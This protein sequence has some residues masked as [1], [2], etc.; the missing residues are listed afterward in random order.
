VVLLQLRV[1]LGV[2]ENVAT[3]DAV[4]KLALAVA[5]AVLVR[6]PKNYVTINNMSNYIFFN[7]CSSAICYLIEL[8]PFHDVLP[9]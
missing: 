1:D 3:R 9:L 5:V 6:V 4:H 8:K 2:G 7:E